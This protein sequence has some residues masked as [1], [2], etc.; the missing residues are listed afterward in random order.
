MDEKQENKRKKF[1][2][3]KIVGRELSLRHALKYLALAVACGLMFGACSGAA[4]LVVRTLGGEKAEAE[5]EQESTGTPAPSEEETETEG[6]GNQPTAEGQ[7]PSRE[8]PESTG[9]G[10]G[11]GTDTGNGE[12]GAAAEPA[13]HEADIRGLVREELGSYRP[14]MEDF[15]AVLQDLRQQT[16]EASTHVV[17]VQAVEQETGW[18]DDTIERAYDAAG[19]I[20]STEDPEIRILTTAAAVKEADKL[21]VTFPDGTVAEAFMKQSSALDGAAVLSVPKTGLGTEFLSSISPIP[22]GNANALETGE[23]ILAV[24][25]PLG[26]THSMD[27]GFLGYRMDNEPVA[28]GT[29]DVFYGDIAAD[30]EKGTFILNL[31]GELVGMVRPSG[32]S[33][34][35]KTEILSMTYLRDIL[36]LLSENKAV[37]YLGVEGRTVSPEMNLESMPAGVYV[38]DVAQDS[39]AYAAGLKRG[40]IITGLNDVVVSDLTGYEAAVRKAEAGSSVKLKAMR[41]TTGGEYQ[42]LE[43]RMTAGSR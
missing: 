36:R 14:D 35:R 25:A 40:D 31:D 22:V 4:F 39:P 5:R 9:A 16:G 23:M 6:A 28:D 3:E 20:L 12:P 11:S 8:E 21:N 10:T 37:P 7:A 26:V 1:I 42:E 43:F 34:G 19:V 24:G 2:S 29:A 27:A 33:S 18:F 41:G 32:D 30:A 15:K 13:A 38:T 17:S